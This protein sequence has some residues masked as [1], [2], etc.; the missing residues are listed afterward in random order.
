M[1]L[2][3][4]SEGWNP[5]NQTVLGSNSN[6]PLDGGDL[7]TGKFSPKCPKLLWI[8]FLHRLDRYDAWS[9]RGFV[10]IDGSIIYYIYTCES[11]PV[12]AP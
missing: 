5:F 4:S 3:Y 6:S 9:I 11:R 8:V 2:I 12:G 7:G 1:C 10:L